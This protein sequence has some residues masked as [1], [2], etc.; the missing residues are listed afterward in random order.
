LDR[1]RSNADRP[2]ESLERIF[3]EPTRDR[4]GLDLAFFLIAPRRALGVPSGYPAKT[5]KNEFVYFA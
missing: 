4:D 1:S 5:C 2:L 3:T